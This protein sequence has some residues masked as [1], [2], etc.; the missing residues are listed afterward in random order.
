MMLEMLSHLKIDLVNESKVVADENNSS[1]KV[2]D[3]ICQSINGL[4]VKMI[5]WFIQQ[6]HVRNLMRQPSKHNSTLL[7][8]RQ[9]FYWGCLCFPRDAISSYYLN[10]IT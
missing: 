10:N 2:V 4:H 3:G 7:S 5:G 6:Q 1:F 9:L 8:V